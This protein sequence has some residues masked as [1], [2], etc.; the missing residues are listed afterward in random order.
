MLEN[1]RRMTEDTSPENLRK[2]LESEDSAMV[3]MGIYLAKG[4]GIDITVNDLEHFLWS[5]DIETIKTGIILADEAKIIEEYFNIVSQRLSNKNEDVK[6][7]AAKIVGVVFERY[8]E[9]DYWD[10]FRFTDS[11]SALHKANKKKL[12]F[13]DEKLLV[14]NL[15]EISNLISGFQGLSFIPRNKNINQKKLWNIIFNND[16]N[17]IKE[18]L[19][20]NITHILESKE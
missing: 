9:L 14:R 18:T 2:F 20:R 16:I 7:G 6:F 19:T 5:D 11:V 17:K 3:Q 1:P 13:E 10:E 8:D 12:E 15:N 4:T